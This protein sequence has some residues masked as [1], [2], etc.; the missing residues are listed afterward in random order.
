MCHVQIGF[1]ETV[2]A[3]ILIRYLNNWKAARKVW[4]EDARRT[5]Q[6]IKARAQALDRSELNPINPGGSTSAAIYSAL[7]DAQHTMQD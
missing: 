6:Q 5:I 2:W 1:H 4:V 7:T 3:L